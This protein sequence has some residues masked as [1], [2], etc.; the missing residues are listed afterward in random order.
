M[1]RATILDVAKA[2][3]LSVSTVNRALHEPEKVR[4]ETLMSVLQAAEIVG[5]Y[6]LGSIR[7]SVKSARPKVRIGILLLQ[8]NR[9]FYK[10]LGVAFEAAAK[11]HRDHEVV[12]QID[13]LDELS[14]QNVSDGLIRLAQKAD[15][16]GVVAPEHPLISATIERLAEAG[17]K[18]FGL[19][20]PL[21]A[22]CGVGYVGLDAWKVGRT[23]AWAC[24][25]LCRNEN[26]KI[27]ILV[28]N[29]RFRCQETNESGF[30]SYMREHASGIVILEPQ[31]TFESANIARE[32][33]ETMLIRHKDLA[34]LF[35][36][37]GG[38]SGVIQAF[39]ESD[40]R[41]NVV[42]VGYDNTEVTQGALLDG[43]MNF[44][45]SHPIARLAQETIQAMT[46]AIT[47][48]ADSTPQ[49]ITL[50]FEIFTPEN[51]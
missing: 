3:G 44:M 5:F 10:S 26:A 15:V 31:S 18:F 25:N 39:R 28:G 42:V 11:S 41:Q 33:T 16:L 51:L 20:S 24:H 22:R 2:S 36:C 50:P 14:P 6:G 29:H 21:T 9:A 47:R 38:I 48:S 32:I 13:Y 34:G 30:R 49:S 35:V 23:A 1:A 37:G 40:R 27:G 19:I 8:R 4:D 45:I 7:E 46:L 17:K 12:I 43:T